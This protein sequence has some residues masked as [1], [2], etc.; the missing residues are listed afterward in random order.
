MASALDRNTRVYA[1]WL[2]WIELPFLKLHRLKPGGVKCLICTEKSVVSNVSLKRPWC[3]CLQFVSLTAQGLPLSVSY[4]VC[5]TKTVSP[6]AGTIWKHRLAW[7]SKVCFN[8]VHQC[9]E[10]VG[11]KY[12]FQKKPLRRKTAKLLFHL[13]KTDEL[14]DS[15]HLLHHLVLFCFSSKYLLM[16]VLLTKSVYG[17]DWMSNKK[18]LVTKGTPNSE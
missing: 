1:S 14:S 17:K 15:C 18:F 5:Q 16:L 2:I 8:W 7:K 10:F 3:L 9:K 12:G 6:E 13:A 4:C 11:S